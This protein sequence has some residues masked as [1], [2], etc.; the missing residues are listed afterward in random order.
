MQNSYNTYDNGRQISTMSLKAAIPYE[1]QHISLSPFP[2][3][4][5][6]HSLLNGRFT[7]DSTFLRGQRK[8]FFLYDEKRNIN[9]HKFVLL[10]VSNL[11]VVTRMAVINRPNVN[12]KLQTTGFL[13]LH[14]LVVH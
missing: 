2:L 8:M 12:T 10:F 1:Q 9:N 3:V 4:F 14:F 5:P 6:L 7:P 13:E 11:V